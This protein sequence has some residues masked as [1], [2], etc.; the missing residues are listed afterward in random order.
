M[1][2]DWLLDDVILDFTASLQF[3]GFNGTYFMES[4]LQFKIKQAI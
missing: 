3:D 1:T 2:H 4:Q